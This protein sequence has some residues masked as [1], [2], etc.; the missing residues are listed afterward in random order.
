MKIVLG[1]VL[2]QEMKRRGLTFYRIS[3]LAGIPESTLADWSSGMTPRN[4]NRVLKLAEI[5]KRDN[6][7]IQE[8][9][10]RLLFGDQVKPPDYSEKCPLP[11]QRG[12]S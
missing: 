8:V 4:L 2:E 6:E 11:L 1:K 5:F 7:S 10:Y 9:F 3:K 12:L